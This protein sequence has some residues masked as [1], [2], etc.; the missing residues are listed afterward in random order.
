MEKLLY[1]YVGLNFDSLKGRPYQEVLDYM[2]IINLITAEE[3][4]LHKKAE[5]EARRG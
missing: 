2:A 1:K 4:R 3:D 5:S